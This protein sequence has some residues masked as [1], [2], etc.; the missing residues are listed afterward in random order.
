M[1]E[2]NRLDNAGPEVVNGWI[3][4]GWWLTGM[5]QYINRFR[6]SSNND[7]KAYVLLKNGRMQ[8][9]E[10]GDSNEANR[11][12]I[13]DISK[14]N[15]LSDIAAK[16]LW[17]SRDYE[18]SLRKRIKESDEEQSL[19][20][21]AKLYGEIVFPD[22]RKWLYSDQFGLFKKKGGEDAL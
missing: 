3:N 8:F 9:I 19:L 22:S 2:L 16:R 18:V 10:Y 5:P 13:Y 4:E 21:M 17:I 14:Y 11:T 7:I 20:E 15:M 1:E 12:T 6:E